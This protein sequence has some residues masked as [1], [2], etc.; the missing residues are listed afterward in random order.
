MWVAFEM[1]EP[2]KFFLKTT[3]CIFWILLVCF[4]ALCPSPGL[5]QY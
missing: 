5:N 2:L 4:D 3:F 1:Q